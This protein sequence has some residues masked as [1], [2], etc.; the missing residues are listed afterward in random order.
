MKVDGTA[1]TVCLSIFFCHFKERDVS[2]VN[3]PVV[4]HPV[5]LTLCLLTAP[6]FVFY[7][8][9]VLYRFLT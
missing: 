3:V 8:V 4:S 6:I 2:V 9:L 7:E 1:H 5:F